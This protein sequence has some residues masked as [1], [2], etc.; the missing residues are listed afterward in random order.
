MGKANDKSIWKWNFKMTALSP[1]PKKKLNYWKVT[2]FLERRG[3]LKLAEH[4]I[5]SPLKLP[6][7]CTFLL[8]CNYLLLSWPHFVEFFII[9]YTVILTI[10]SNLYTISKLYTMKIY[11]FKRPLNFFLYC[12]KWIYKRT[13][14][15]FYILLSELL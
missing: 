1:Q 2:S 8:P 3:R 9:W 7:F 6:L 11:F 4:F 5:L 10:I 15:R 13:N 14:F 12:I